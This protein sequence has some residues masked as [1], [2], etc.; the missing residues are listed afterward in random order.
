MERVLFL[1]TRGR[2]SLGVL[3]GLL[4][5]GRK[6]VSIAVP[7]EGQG[8]VALSPPQPVVSELPMVASFVEHGVVEIGWGQGIPVWEAG[9]LNEEALEAIRVLDLSAIVVACW[10]RLLPERLLA[11]PKWGVLNVHPS[12]LP[13]WRGPAPVFW[14]LRAGLRQIGVTIHR[15]SREFD[16]GPILA[17]APL[18][19]PDGATGEEI[20]ELVAELGARL[21]REV[22]DGLAA[23]TLG[24]REQKG[25]GS[26][27]GWPTEADFHVPRGW[28]AQRARNF[29]R[30]TAEWGIPFTVTG[31]DGPPILRSAQDRLDDS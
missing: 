2:L 9:R 11:I 16:E 29:V 13:E 5:Q 4:G 24:E 7:G 15:M 10:P 28:S 31:D 14:Q 1:G 3:G 8:L 26:Y 25:E 19:L 18:A 6:V 17:Q 30:G 23:G 27:Q 21:L 22:L 20:D 12:L